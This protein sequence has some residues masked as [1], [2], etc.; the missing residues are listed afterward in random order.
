MTLYNNEII[1]IFI[2]NR[3]WNETKYETFD[4]KKT[5]RIIILCICKVGL[6]ANTVYKYKPG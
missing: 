5:Q 3:Q 4:Y 2:S 6:M 1:I